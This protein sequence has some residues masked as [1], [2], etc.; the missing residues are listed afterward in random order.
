MSIN[1]YTI[2]F[3]CTK[4][5]AI[6]PSLLMMTIVAL[7][8]FE[9]VGNYKYTLNCYINIGFQILILFKTLLHT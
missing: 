1:L 8:F 9:Y 2:L 5:V 6:K 4:M 7:I 3:H